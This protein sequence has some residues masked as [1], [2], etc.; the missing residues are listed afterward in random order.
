MHIIDRYAYGNAI[1]GVD[2]AQKGGLALIAML[3]CL[4]LKQPAVGLLTLGWM[5]ALATLWARVPA[6]A[7]GRALLTEAPFLLLSLVGV[8]LSVSLAP[9]AGP[10]LRLGP[11][12]IGSGPESLLLAMR[13]FTR[14]L[15]C[16]AALNFLILTTPLLDL[17]ELLRRLRMPETLIDLMS[18]T[19]RAIAVL[20]ESLQRMATA[21]DARLGYAGPWRALR[22]ASLL[23][24][25]LFLDAYRRS[26]RLQ[27]ALESRGLAGPLRVLPLAYRRDRR[28]RWF[29]AALA[30]SLLLVGV[31]R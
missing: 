27:M 22:S 2:P 24:S 21:Q 12:W 14:A 1:R 29:G 6:R 23:G 5:F 8:A 15:G 18:L 11:L 10:A 25:Q 13:L 20:L 26:Q 9:L 3:L 7:F 28:A 16:A 31:W 4:V 19:Y 17:I 30:A